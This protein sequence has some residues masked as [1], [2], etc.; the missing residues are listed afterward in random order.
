LGEYD[1]VAIGRPAHIKLVT[2]TPRVELLLTYRDFTPNPTLTPAD[3]AVPRPSGVVV[4]HL[5]P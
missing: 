5:Q 3:L 4:Q 2:T 1:K